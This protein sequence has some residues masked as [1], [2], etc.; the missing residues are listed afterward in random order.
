[1]PIEHYIVRRSPEED[2]PDS[3]TREMLN[4]IEERWVRDKCPLPCQVAVLDSL[5]G[6][7][8]LGVNPSQGVSWTSISRCQLR[9]TRCGAERETE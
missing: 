6:S 8:S 3:L 5:S 1:M 9:L 4:L 7:F 2:L